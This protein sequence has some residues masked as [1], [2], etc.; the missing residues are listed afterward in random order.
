MQAS[1]KKVI[2]VTG[3]TGRQGGAVARHLIRDAWHVRGLTRNPDSAKARALAAAGAELVQGDMGERSSLRSAF[4]DAYGVYSVQNPMISGLEAE[5][6]QGKL[7]AD[8]AMEVGVSHLVYASAGT[9]HTNTGIGS[10][11]SKQQVEQHLRRVGVPFTILRLVAFMEIMT[12]KAFFPAAS[13]WH[14]L[15]KLMGS[16]RPLGWLCLDDLGA[17][18]AKVF[19]APDQF[20][21]CELELLADVRTIDECRALYRDA[22]GKAPPRIP[23]PVWLF[24]RFVGTDLTTMWRWLG[25]A[26]IAWDTSTARAIHPDALTVREWLSRRSP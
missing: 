4:H 9:G 3:A 25:N 8:V 21:G 16:A 20:L 26:D 1:D 6:Q 14:V 10:W 19:A 22:A 11:E 15:P 18:A 13:S 5:V 12:D 7:V 24:E 2:V 17:I 23:M